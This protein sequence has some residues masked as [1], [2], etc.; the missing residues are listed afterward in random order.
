MEE[1][2]FPAEHKGRRVVVVHSLEQWRDFLLDEGASSGAVWLTVWKK[3]APPGRPRYDDVV[4]EALCHGWID[5][6]INRFDEWSVLLMMAPR[7]RGS[8]WSAPN[9]DRV[10]RM[11][12]QGRMRAS[13][14][15][16][17]QAALADGSWSTLDTV[18]ALEEPDDLRSAIDAAGLRATWERWSPSRRKQVLYRLVLAR[19]DTTRATRVDEAIVELRGA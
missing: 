1:P 9:K 7:K 4:E 15:A 12:A 19:T 17:I 6:T 2:Q 10:E 5:S 3:A 11:T 13:G 8:V 16:A 18:D 14:R